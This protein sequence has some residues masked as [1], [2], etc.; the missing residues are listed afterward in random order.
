MILSCHNS[1]APELTQSWID[2]QLLSH[3]L[4]SQAPPGHSLSQVE[5]AAQLVG[6]CPTT[7]SE[8]RASALTRVATRLASVLPHLYPGCGYEKHH[9]SLY[10]GFRVPRSHPP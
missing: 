9:T 10:D 6:S 5:V 7:P 3:S 4:Q 8:V 2:I 1:S